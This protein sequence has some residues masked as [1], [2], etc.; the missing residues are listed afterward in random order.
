MAWQGR[1]GQCSAAVGRARQRRHWLCRRRQ[2]SGWGSVARGVEQGWAGQGNTCKQ[3]AFH[4]AESI[5]LQWSDAYKAKKEKKDK[6]DRENA[7]RWNSLY[8]NANTVVDT[9]AN[10]LNVD[11]D[12][13]IG[14]DEVCLLCRERWGSGANREV[15]DSAVGRLA[16]QLHPL[17]RHVYVHQCL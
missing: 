11:K 5:E 6:Q 3:A 10:R 4:C 12:K 9:I 15:V 7:N 8:I 16:K 14:Q 1:A 17:P 13:L 2:G